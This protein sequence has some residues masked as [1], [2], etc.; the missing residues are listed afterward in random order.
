MGCGDDHTAQPAG[1][2][3]RSRRIR[4][5]PQ[6]AGLRVRPGA[7]ARRASVSLSQPPAGRLTQAHRQQRRAAA[8]RPGP[9]TH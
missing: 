3:A 4:P 1:G 2:S 7:R 5:A 8:A 6:A 9:L